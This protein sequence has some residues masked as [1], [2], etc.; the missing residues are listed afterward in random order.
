[1]L[2]LSIHK[3]GGYPT[4]GGSYVS[5]GCTSDYA[6]S[7][8]KYAVDNWSNAKITQSD[9]KVDELGYKARLITKEE[10]TKTLGCTSNYCGNSS[11]TWTYNNNYYYWTMSPWNNSSSRVWFVNSVGYLNDFGVGTLDGVVRP[12]ITLYKSAL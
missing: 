9:L 1:M 11:Y 3:R 5:G 12:V 6:S 4:V 10:L 7:E 8:I 2:L